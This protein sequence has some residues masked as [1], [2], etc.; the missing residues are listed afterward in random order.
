[1]LSKDTRYLLEKKLEEL[2]EKEKEAQSNLDKLNKDFYDAWQIY[3]S[4]LAGSPS[5][6]EKA[7]EEVSEARR[8]VALVK[9]LLNGT[10]KLTD[11][12]GARR[13]SNELDRKIKEIS[14]QKNDVDREIADYDA[15]RSLLD[16]SILSLIDKKK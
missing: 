14:K 8:K 1:M 16:P 2:K 13:R 6:S 12:V 5:G 7:A 9:G 10:Y 4:E 11:E 15:I 3:G